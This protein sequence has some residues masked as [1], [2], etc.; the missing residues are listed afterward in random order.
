LKKLAGV[1]GGIA[2]AAV[3][4]AC[5]SAPSTTSGTETWQGKQVLTPAQ[6]ANNNFQPTYPMTFT[7]PVHATGT[8]TPPGGN[9][10]KVTVTFHTSAGNLV[11]NADLPGNSNQNAPPTSFNA[12]TCVATFDL[13]GTYTVAGGSSTGSFKGATG[14]GTIRDAYTITLPKLASGACNEANS[15]QPLAGHTSLVVSGPMTVTS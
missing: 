9:K 11:A 2:I 10:V 15:A 3:A 12:K 5:S 14:H 13:N 7:G 6:L 4:A 8:F 1:A